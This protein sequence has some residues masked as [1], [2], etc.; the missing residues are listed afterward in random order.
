MPRSSQTLLEWPHK[1]M[2]PRFCVD[3]V[4]ELEMKLIRSHAFH[5]DLI[6]SNKLD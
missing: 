3:N 1:L 6:K 5:Y 2:S 4:A